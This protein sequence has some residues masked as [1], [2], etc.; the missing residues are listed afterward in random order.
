VAASR[1]GTLTFDC[2]DPKR[3]SAF[4]SAAL[5]FEEYDADETDVVIRDPSGVDRDLLFQN[6]P[7]GKSVKNRLH[8][9]LIP[10]STMKEEVERLRAAGASEQRYVVEGDSYWTI[11]EDPEGNEF[12][13]LRGDSERAQAT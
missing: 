6:V 13:V 4:W 1:I 8:L 3:L 5:G 11:M 12:C 2:R 10:P 7:E 9:D